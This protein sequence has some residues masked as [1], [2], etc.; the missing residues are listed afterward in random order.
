MANLLLDMAGRGQG[1]W[2]RTVYGTGGS[3][4]IPPDRTGKPLSL[5]RRIDGKDVTL[6]AD[7]ILALVPDFKLDAT[8]AALFGGE[9]L[10]SYELPWADIDANLIGIEY[11]DFA[12]AIRDD[13]EPEVN[14]EDGLRSL[15]LMYGMMESERAGRTLTTEELFSG[16]ASIYQDEIGE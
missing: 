15:A 12:A 16:A 5:A 14:G 8:T 6:S 1:H 2:L 11:D 4:N 10:T 3:L 13:R 7:E 9:R